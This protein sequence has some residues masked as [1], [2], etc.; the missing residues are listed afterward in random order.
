M[1]RGSQYQ[2]RSPPENTMKKQTPNSLKLARPL[3]AAALLFASAGSQAADGLTMR[4]A[5]GVG[6]W[7]AAQGNAA[8]REIDGDLR[9]QLHE[10]I[11]PLLP[12]REPRVVETVQPDVVAAN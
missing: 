11:K 1:A 3:I 9:Q 5:S 2:L 8:L 6:T 10:R 7:I 4:G 12:Q